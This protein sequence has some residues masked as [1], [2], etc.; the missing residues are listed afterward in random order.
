M[1][2]VRQILRILGSSP[3]TTAFPAV[4]FFMYR[5]RPSATFLRF[6]KFLNGTKSG[7]N[8]SDFTEDVSFEDCEGDDT[9]EQRDEGSE[10][11]L[12][13]GEDRQEFLQ[14][15]LLLATA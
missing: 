14:L 11:Q 4:V 9:K 1:T 13:Q 15:L 10:L 6:E 2:N 3:T 7:G 12:D 5:F 8:E